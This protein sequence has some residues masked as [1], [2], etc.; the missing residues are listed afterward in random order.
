MPQVGLV[1]MFL[2]G[3]VFLLAKWISGSEPP[4]P[5]PTPRESADY[6]IQ[7][8]CDEIYADYMAQNPGSTEERWALEAAEE[9]GC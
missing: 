4:S 3:C 6:S 8:S 1:V 9:K 7:Q 5:G 2:I